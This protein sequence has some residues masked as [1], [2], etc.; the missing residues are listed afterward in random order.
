MQFTTILLIG[1]TSYFAYS[2]PVNNEATADLSGLPTINEAGTHAKNLESFSATEDMTTHDKEKEGT[3]IHSAAHNEATDAVLLLRS[4][5][6]NLET[7]WDSEDKTTSGTELGN[8]MNIAADNKAKT[9]YV[10]LKKMYQ[11]YK[12]QLEKLQN[13]SPMSCD[14]DAEYWWSRAPRRLF[15]LDCHTTRAESTWKQLAVSPSTDTSEWKSLRV[16]LLKVSV[17]EGF[18]L[19]TQQHFVNRKVVPVKALAQLLEKLYC[20]VMSWAWEIN[21]EFER[22]LEWCHGPHRENSE[23]IVGF[24]EREFEEFIRLLTCEEMLQGHF[25]YSD[26][27]GRLQ[28]STFDSYFLTG[29]PM[30]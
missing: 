27:R 24:I 18:S 29:P 8:T 25:M 19:A 30:F 14:Y 5:W 12:Q 26:D 10:P 11:I 28:P 13:R 23:K 21:A 9:E 2:A 1:C 22:G 20:H 7:Y 4:Q 16:A 3:Q 6:K 17:M 15:A